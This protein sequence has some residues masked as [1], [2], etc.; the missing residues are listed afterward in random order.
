MH[1]YCTG[2]GSPTVI[3]EAG[4][5]DSSLIWSTIQPEIANSTRV[6]SYDRAGY[7]WSEESPFPRIANTQ[8]EELHK[9]LVNASIQGP[10]VM[11]GHS[12]GGMIVRMYAHNY[13]NDVNGVTYTWD[14]NGNLLNDGTNTFTYDYANRLVSLTNGV[15]NYN[16]HYNGLGDRIQQT[17]NGVTTT[18][19]LDLN[20]GL[21]QVLS[22]GTDTYLY[23]LSRIGEEDTAWDYYLGDALGS[24][25]QLADFSGA[26]SLA[27]TFE[28]YGEVLNT[29]GNGSSNYNFTGEWTDSYIKLVYLRSRYYAPTT[30]RFLTKDISQGNY[31]R[32]L[33]LNSW[34]YTLG[35]PVNYTDPSGHI[36]ESDWEAAT[37]LYKFL[38]STYNV[39]IERDW[40]IIFTE[41]RN[42]LA[43]AIVIR[44]ILR[45]RSISILAKTS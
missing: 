5:G 24:V 7:G 3:L 8:V 6:C 16:Y 32:P 10:Y 12:L 20:V 44:H 2:Q 28:P 29:F 23:G 17:V 33:S 4:M 41:P 13:P 15:D 30:G 26:V 35:N 39:R 38:L 18:Y 34:N 31:N 1:I 45:D 42:S 25:R 19:V 36:P 14:N 40:R 22:D 9:L 27:Q 21:T 43:D 37:N 11:V